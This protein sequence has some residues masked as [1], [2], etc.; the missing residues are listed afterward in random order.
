MERAVVQKIYGRVVIHLEGGT[1]TRV[2]TEAMELPPKPLDAG[3]GG[4]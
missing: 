2:V 4:G 1:I 3:P